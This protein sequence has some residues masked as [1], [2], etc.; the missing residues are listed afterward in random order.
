[1]GHTLEA[2]GRPH[3]H[4]GRS[5]TTRVTRRRHKIAVCTIALCL[6]WARGAMRSCCCEK[7]ATGAH[8]QLAHVQTACVHRGSWAHLAQGECTRAQC[9]AV[10]ME[11]VLYSWTTCESGTKRCGTTLNNFTYHLVCSSKAPV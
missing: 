7:V 2:H 6:R 1:V 10:V 8:A 5:H 11:N 9:L 4:C 3:V